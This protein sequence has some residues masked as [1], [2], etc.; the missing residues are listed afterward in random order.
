M[1]TKHAVTVVTPLA[2]YLAWLKQRAPER[3]TQAYI[4]RALAQHGSPASAMQV[5]LWTTGKRSPDAAYKEALKEI[6]GGL[7]TPAQW[8]EWEVSLTATADH[9]PRGV[10]FVCRRQSSKP[11]PRGKAKTPKKTS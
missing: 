6:S 1:P 7:C 4:V 11:R 3:A 2:T 5:S 9:H 10:C 8:H